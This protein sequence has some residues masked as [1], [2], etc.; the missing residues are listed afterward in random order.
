VGVGPS[1]GIPRPTGPDGEIQEWT[2]LGLG[3]DALVDRYVE[4]VPGWVPPD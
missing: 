1:T 3:L 2:L 4:P